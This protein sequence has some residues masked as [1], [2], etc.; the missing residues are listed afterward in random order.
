MGLPAVEIFQGLDLNWPALG[1]DQLQTV[2]AQTSLGLVY[3]PVQFPLAQGLVPYREQI[4]KR[5]TLATVEIMWSPYAGRSNLVS[6]Y[7]HP[8]TEERTQDAF[9]QRDTPFFHHC[10]GAGGQL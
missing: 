1:L 6:G 8:P 9:T 2:F 3:Q 4:G 5:P 10:E 7:V